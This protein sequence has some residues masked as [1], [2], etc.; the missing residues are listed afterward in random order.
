MTVICRLCG[1]ETGNGP[2]GTEPESSLVTSAPEAADG[3][4]CAGCGAP[5]PATHAAAAFLEKLKQ[6]A[7]FGLTSNARL[8]SEVSGTEN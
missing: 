1:S 4:C 6:L 2:S 8:L 3:L 7:Q 5:L